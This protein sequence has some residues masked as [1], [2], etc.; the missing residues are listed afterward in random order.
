[1]T[2]RNEPNAP[3]G[4]DT[5]AADVEQQEVAALVKL[6]R[7][8]NHSHELDE[9]DASNER[10]EG[11]KDNIGANTR[12]PAI[13]GEPGASKQAALRANIVKAEA[14]YTTWHSA[15][16]AEKARLIEDG[17]AVTQT[18]TGLARDGGDEE[19][20]RDKKQ[21]DALDMQ[22]SNRLY[23]KKIK[24]LS[25]ARKKLDTLTK[26]G[27]TAEVLEAATL[28]LRQLILEAGMFANEAM[29]TRGAS[30]FVVYG[31]QVAVDMDPNATIRMTEAQFFHA[32][33]EQLADT[34]KE[35]GH[36]KTMK[37]GIYK[38]GKYLMRMTLAFDQLGVPPGGIPSLAEL[39]TLGDWAM[40]AKGMSE[41]DLDVNQKQTQ[42]G[43][44]L[45]T[46]FGGTYPADADPAAFIDNVVVPFG[47]AVT[48]QYKM[49]AVDTSDQ[50]RDGRVQGVGQGAALGQLRTN[51]GL[52]D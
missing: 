52:D 51:A 1:M 45:E 9:L 20:D 41:D 17:E 7:F 26:K 48:S 25:K 16:E 37:E 28:R 27:A 4:L 19:A 47:A 3:D 50:M 5:L 23:E 10:W 32:F 24:Q 43:N 13:V 22:A 33:T 30:N 31:T 49:K 46:Q 15:L 35:F 29:V 2:I 8:M 40:A 21:D 34:V 12:S 39:R 44:F 36:F 11:Y 14:N 6:I 42:L 38:G 18:L